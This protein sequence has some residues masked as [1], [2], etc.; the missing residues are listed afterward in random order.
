MRAIFM[1]GYDSR[2][3]GVEERMEKLSGRIAVVT[4]GAS[5][6]GLGIARAAASEG[7]RV[8]LL[9]VE[10]RALD[11]AC[12]ALGGEAL[13]IRTDVSDPAS[14]SAAAERVLA[15][16]GRVD[17]LCNNAGVLVS[18]PLVE[19]K[20]RDWEWV[21]GVNLLG[22]AHGVRAFVPHIRAGGEGGHVVNTASVVGLAGMPGLGVY[23]ATKYAV[24]ALSEVLR[25]ELAPEGIGVSVLCPGGVRTRIHDAA[26]NRPAVLGGPE[27]APRRTA[28]DVAVETGMD[29]DAVGRRVVR[30]IRANEP[31]VL[32]HP[33]FRAP[34]AARA[35][36][37]L[38]AFDR[39]AREN[40]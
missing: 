34:F 33:E 30:A 16:F 13:G 6:I 17:V 23:T 29:P 37:I 28:T 26:R 9:D 2:L 8:A 14:L 35:E 27:A 31:Y 18:G 1:A 4:G 32:T 19:S 20:P 12:A 24:V 11:A 25:E 5:G 38:G 40:E 36:A 7:M 22:V 21:V 15:R 10:E 3:A 39:A